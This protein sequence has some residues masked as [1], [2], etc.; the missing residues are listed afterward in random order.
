MDRHLLAE[1]LRACRS[2]LDEASARWGDVTIC[3]VTKTVDADT[4]NMA[5]DEGI[6]IIGEN[7]VQEAREKF[8]ALNPDFCLHIIGQLQTNKVKYLMGMARM[9]QSLDRMSLA[10][11]IDRRAQAAGIRMPV[12]LQVNIARE[13]QK[14][15][16]FEEEIVSFAREAARLP[17]LSIEGLMAIMPISSDPEALRPLF[18]GMRAWFDRLRDEAIAGVDMRVLSMGM[19]SDYIIAAEEGTTMVRL[20]SAIFG[21]RKAP[22]S[23]MV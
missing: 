23:S 22:V 16:I 5:Y 4:I 10:Q 14:A 19:S 9:I 12:L 3:A 1:N 21:V 13:P 18:R 17:G 6:R 20:G 7:R 8:P 2:R 15:G 11:E